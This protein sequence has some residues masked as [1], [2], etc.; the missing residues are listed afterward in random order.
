M[1]IFNDEITSIRLGIR[2][3]EICA[4]EEHY[5]RNINEAMLVGSWAYD[6]LDAVKESVIGTFWLAWNAS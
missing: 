3:D 6:T 1:R 4:V 5:S 2:R